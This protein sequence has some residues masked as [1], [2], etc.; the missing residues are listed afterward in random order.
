MFAFGLSIASQDREMS[1]THVV[2]NVLG[3]GWV[4][5][6]QAKTDKG[7]FVARSQICCSDH[8]VQGISG[9]LKSKMRSN[10]DKASKFWET[11]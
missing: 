7:D 5:F 3:M 4:N 6:P 2:N 8:I 1:L 9:L 11:L 10:V